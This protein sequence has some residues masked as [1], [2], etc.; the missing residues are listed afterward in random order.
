[1]HAYIYDVHFFLNWRCFENNLW[2][3]TAVLSKQKVL[4]NLL[5]VQR[6]PSEAVSYLIGKQHAAGVTLQ[7]SHLDQCLGFLRAI[8]ILSRC[9]FRCAP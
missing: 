5:F 9:L 4:E 3:S 8:G 1:M 6:R 2:E 7:N